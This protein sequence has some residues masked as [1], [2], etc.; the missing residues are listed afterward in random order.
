MGW[1]GFGLGWAGFGLGS[2]CTAL[3]FGSDCVAFVLL[4]FNVHFSVQG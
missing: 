4:S 3:S 2:K 1:A